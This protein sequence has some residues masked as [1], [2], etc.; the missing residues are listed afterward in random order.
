[1]S[2]QAKFFEVANVRLAAA[3]F[4][5]GIQTQEEAPPREAAGEAV[6]AEAHQDSAWEALREAEKPKMSLS[7]SELPKTYKVS[8]SID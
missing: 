8:R 5:P 3:G 7:R 1:M 6:P 4:G 2:S